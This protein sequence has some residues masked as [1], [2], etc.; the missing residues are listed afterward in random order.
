MLHEPALPYEALLDA[1]GANET[2]LETMRLLHRAIA[3]NLVA[4][5]T[6][7]SPVILGLAGSQGS[8]KSTQS[9]LLQ[10]LCQEEHGLTTCILS[11]DD[12]YLSRAKRRAL[13]RDIHP[14]LATRGVPGTHDIAL[15]QATLDA[16][17]NSDGTTPVAIP[18]FDKATDDPL[19]KES[20]PRILAPVDVIIFEGWCVGAKPQAQT[21]LEAPIN[22]LESREDP[23]G[24]WRSYVNT[25]LESDYAALFRRIDLLLMLAAPNFEIVFNW[26]KKQEDMLRSK[27]VGTDHP[28]LM[29]DT[30]LRRFIMHYQRITEAMLHEMPERA[31]CVV[32]LSTDQR[33]V[34]V[35]WKPEP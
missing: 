35:S 15:A 29:N 12:V 8:G 17:S 7:P 2:A 19:P 21:T 20:W 28:G 14:L 23:E 26:R 11:I 31:D 22:E 33:P 34:S 16:L 1:L 30:E 3:D 24:H 18:R 32:R 25:A 13:S 27:T 4:R 6:H 10:A 5:H 9:K